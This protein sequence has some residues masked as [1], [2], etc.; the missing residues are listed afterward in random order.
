MTPDWALVKLRVAFGDVPA[1][2]NVLRM[3]S[4]RRYQVIKVAGKTLHA[5]VLPSQHRTGRSKVIP[6]FWAPRRRRG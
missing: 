6:W 4:G 5:L 3:P 1:A 2:G